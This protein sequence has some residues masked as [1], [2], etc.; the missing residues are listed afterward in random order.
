MKLPSSKQFQGY[1]LKS[2]HPVYREYVGQKHPS[3][4]SLFLSKHPEGFKSKV[5][6]FP[7]SNIPECSHSH[8]KPL[9]MGLNML[10]FLSDLDTQPSCLCGLLMLISAGLEFQAAHVFSWEMKL[11]ILLKWNFVLTQIQG[12]ETNPSVVRRR[13]AIGHGCTGNPRAGCTLDTTPEILSVVSLSPLISSTGLQ[14]FI[15]LCGIGYPMVM[16]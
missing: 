1:S 9:L 15:Y 2:G 3:F 4:E 14:V 13:T 10:M 6:C 12:E 16:M 8:L 11:I 5:S 7:A